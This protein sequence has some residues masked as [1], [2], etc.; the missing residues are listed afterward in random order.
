MTQESVITQEMRDVIG[1]ES[2]AITYD[3]ERGAIR[4]FAEAIGD[5]NPL[6][7][8]EE[9]AR[10][11][12]YGG[13]IA[14]PTFMRS[15]SAGRSRATVQSPYPAALD[16]GSEWEYFEP[17]RPGDRISVTMKVSEMFE[18]EGRL[19]N[20]LFIIRETSYVN[21]FG[22]TVAIQRGTGISYQ[23]SD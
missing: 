1:V 13:V 7:V 15:M 10:K 16:G 14:P 5:D 23:P 8:D 22:K 17:V 9:A 21:Q 19:G 2:E 6:Y 12:R 4:K 11:S 3:V 20:M 18:R